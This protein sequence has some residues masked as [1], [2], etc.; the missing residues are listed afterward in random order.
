MKVKVSS[1]KVTV[2]EIA[3]GLCDTHFF[4]S[5]SEDEFDGDTDFYIYI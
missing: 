5:H 1:N 2:L 4:M 3:P